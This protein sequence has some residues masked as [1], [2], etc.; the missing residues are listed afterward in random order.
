MTDGPAARPALRILVCPQE[1]KGSLDPIAAARA[2]A[3]GVRRAL[4]AA[5]V[6]ELP[7]A[8]GGPGTVALVA[9]AGG[10]RIVRHEARGP[11]GAPVQAAYALIERPGGPAT[12][13][14]EAAATAGLVLVPEAERDPG[15]ASSAGVGEQVR[16]AL[17]AGARRVVVGVGGTA[18]NDGGAGA[19]QA[20]G[21]RLLDPAGGPLASDP[22]HLARLARIEADAV[23]PALRDVEV[24]LAV[25]VMNPLLG[26]R[27]AT[28]VYGAQKGVTDWLA[29]ALDAALARWAE[30]LREDLGFDVT[31]LEGAGAGGGMPAGILAA[32][33][34]A[35]AR[36]SIESG[37]AL[38][39]EAI[40][41][42]AAI[43]A[44]DLVVT[45]EGRLDAQS[46]YGKAVGHVIR[47]A[48]EA[49]RPCLAVAGSIEGLPDGI[50]GAEPLVAEGTPP[51]EAMARAAELVEAASER[52][53]RRWA[54]AG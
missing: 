30:R 4:P 45:G 6:H 28:A 32:A 50:D 44:A 35:G 10:A 53:V 40:G 14:I 23:D 47:L 36:S 11:L 49:G 27:G 33:H 3:A 16:H 22:L 42:R 1:F 8:D 37:A 9:A 51:A 31:T 34:A 48:R 46:G 7:I 25:D 17:A 54:S 26:P 29:P 20:L 43:E 19:A 13:I 21:L 15:R 12:A 39:A 5:E 41:L 2:I 38:V 24:R 18:T 52:L